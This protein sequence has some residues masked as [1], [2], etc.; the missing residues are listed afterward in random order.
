[1][2][3]PTEAQFSAFAA[4]MAKLAKRLIPQIHDEYRCSDDPDD[5]TPGMQVTV[6]VTVED[7]G[8]LSWNYQTGDNSYAGGAYGHPT[9]GI[10]YLYRDTD[11]EEFADSITTDV[12]DTIHN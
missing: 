2:P 8:T 12:A 6:G 9:W 11:P 3:H 1:M 4:D 5:E 7:D 10:G